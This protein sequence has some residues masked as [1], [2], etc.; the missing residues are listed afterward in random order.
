MFPRR[1][2]DSRSAAWD[3]SLD[4]TWSYSM[5]NAQKHEVVCWKTVIIGC[6]VVVVVGVVVV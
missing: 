1:V 5:L 6:G 3:Q 4:G 2:A